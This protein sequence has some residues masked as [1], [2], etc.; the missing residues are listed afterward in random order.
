MSRAAIEILLQNDATLA[1]YGVAQNAIFNQHDIDE[2]PRNDG[3][4]IVIRWE[5]S[6]FFTQSYTGMTNGLDRAPRM[7]TLCVHSPLEVS[8]DFDA[9]DHI[10]DR[11]DE[12]F[13]EVEQLDGPDGNTITTIRNS[14]RSGDLKDEEW[15]TVYRNAAYAVLYR[16][17]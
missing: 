2:R 6:T 5:E 12:M 3:P 4:F 13:K 14:G 16:R 17:S 1:G 15:M 10:I 7:L 9:I 11:I 8:T